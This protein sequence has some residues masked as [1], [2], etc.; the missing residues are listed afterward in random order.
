MSNPKQKVDPYVGKILITRRRNKR[1]TAYRS[2]I[3]KRFKGRYGTYG[4]TV[5]PRTMVRI[6]KVPD[7]LE[8]LARRFRYRVG[9]DYHPW[10]ILA[11]KS[12]TLYDSYIETK[13]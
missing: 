6:T 7:H 13:R 12:D 1:H 4:Y 10:Q 2:E 3:T 9:K 8:Y 11:Q 5:M